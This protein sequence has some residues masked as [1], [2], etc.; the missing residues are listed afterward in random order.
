M[1]RSEAGTESTPG[2]EPCLHLRLMSI[3]TDTADDDPSDPWF[4]CLRT[5]FASPNDTQ[6]KKPIALGGW[7]ARAE[8]VLVVNDMIKRP[9]ELCT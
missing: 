2:I 3:L 5:P 4:L 9:P 6:Q 1:G 7:N 8:G